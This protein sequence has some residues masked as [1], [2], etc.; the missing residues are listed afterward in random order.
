MIGARGVGLLGAGD[1]AGE[2][3]GGGSRDGGVA[4]WRCG[5]VRA[6]GSWGVVDG[7]RR[8]GMG[9]AAPH[10]PYPGAKGRTAHKPS[11]T[12]ARCTHAHPS[13]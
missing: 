9:Q 3:A 10:V 12:L 11:L 7:Q 8:L 1:A 4:G 6:G 2:W 13:E 5:R